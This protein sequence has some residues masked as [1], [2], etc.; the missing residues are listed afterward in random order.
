MEKMLVF[1]H[2]N[3][4]TD[5]I[6]SAI[7]YSHLLNELGYDTEPVALGEASEETQYALK[8][9]NQQPL[10]VIEKAKPETNTVVLVDHNEFQQSVADI[11]ELTIFSVVDHHRIS[12]FKTSGPLYYLA[13]PIGCT[14]SVI[15]GLYQE[16]HVTITPDLAGLMLSGL[17]SDTLLLKSP[18]CTDEDKKIAKELA[19]L[20]DVDL[21]EYGLNLLRSGTDISPLTAEE[22]VDGDAKTFPLRSDATLRIGQVNVVDVNDALDRKEELLK[23]MEELN[24]KDGYDAFILAITN[25]LSSDS[26][27]LVLAKNESLY[28]DIETAFNSKIVDHELDLPGVVSRKKQ[29]V[30]PLTEAIK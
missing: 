16:H 26:T 9:F 7:T 25:I 8:A 21:E 5:A 3:P 18:T 17:L 27:G 1:G 19:K 29:I 4:D 13:K 20:A 28:Q 11:E 23:K 10:R 22:I 24:K 30:P 15:Y 6:T 2:Q 14:Q 12:N